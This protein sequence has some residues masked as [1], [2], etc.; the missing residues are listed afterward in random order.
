MG[1]SDTDRDGDDDI[2]AS[3]PLPEAVVALRKAVKDGSRRP[4]GTVIV[5]EIPVAFKKPDVR[6]RKFTWIH[7]PHN[8]PTWVKVRAPA[9]LT[10]YF[11]PKQV[12]ADNA[13]A[14]TRVSSEDV[15]EGL[16]IAV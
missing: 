5:D 3:P 9:L 8:N 16:F 12:D 2:E 4:S 15:P 7:V 1:L 14:R 11:N 6:D 13:A 10:R